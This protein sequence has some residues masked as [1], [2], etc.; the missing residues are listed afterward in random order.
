MK[1]LEG[2]KVL[3]FTQVHAGSLGTMLL[4]DFGAEVIKVERIGVGDISR[5]WEPMK[6]GASGYF[7]SINRNKKSI[8]INAAS[9]EGKE[10]IEKLV[11]EVDV[12]TENFKL[13]SMERMG[14][15]YEKFQEINPGIIYARLNGYGQ[16]GSLK[17]AMGLEIQM[18]AGS[19]MMERTGFA[20]GP[21]VKVG[22]AISDHTSGTY[23][24]TAIALALV[25]REK[26]G[27]GQV[28]DI[29]I[30]DSLFS[31][32]EANVAQ[33]SLKGVASERT[34]NG[35]PGAAGY[36]TYQAKDGYIAIGISTGRQWK[37]FCTV[38]GMEDILN[39]PDYK[40]AASRWD[41]YETSLLAEIESYTMQF[42]RDE[43]QEK[44]WS[45]GLP[46]GA[47]ATPEE[48]MES[49]QVKA[50]EMVV[51]IDDLGVG[52]M[53]IQG[54]I[55]KMEKT[56]GSVDASA[57]LR[58]QDTIHYLESIGY[59]KEKIEALQANNIVEF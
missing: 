56:P 9:P 43:I 34:G 30:L 21:P 11:K 4:A 31:L 49:E 3:D 54:V 17:Q 26:T 39:N 22:A 36:D 10:I 16:K 15:T 41:L 8:S 24:A 44:L 52:P 57:P 51:D 28:I 19:G 1:P 32:M 55:V 42:T 29:S 20:G 58:G 33:Y 23:M 35:Y 59:S 37:T 40:T 13:G 5:Y 12:V 53:K 6:D 27:K 45:V 48:A 7:A 46:C 14:F 38:M 47:V 50:R 18:Q 25:E 2:I